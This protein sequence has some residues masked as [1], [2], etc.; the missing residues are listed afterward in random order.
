VLEGELDMATAPIFAASLTEACKDRPRG[1]P[2][3]TTTVETPQK[4]AAGRQQRTATLVA[5]ESKAPTKKRK[6]VT[7]QRHVAKTAKRR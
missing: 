4:K 7:A 2:K 1:K 3:R 6:A 5:K